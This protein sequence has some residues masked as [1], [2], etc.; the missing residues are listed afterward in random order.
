MT[1]APLDRA[2]WPGEGHAVLLTPDEGL[3]V[4]APDGA[5][6]VM[7]VSAYLDGPGEGSGGE[8]IG[9]LRGCW[10]D[11]AGLL[12]SATRIAPLALEAADAAAA[13]VDARAGR[14]LFLDVVATAF[15]MAEQHLLRLREA[16]EAEGAAG[17]H[18]ARLRYAFDEPTDGNSVKSLNKSQAF[19]WAMIRLLAGAED[20][21]AFRRRPL[22][23]ALRGALASRLRRPPPAAGA[24]L[25]GGGL[26]RLKGPLET[27][28]V[29]RIAEIAPET[30]HVPALRSGGLRDRLA[31]ALRGPVRRLLAH[32]GVPGEVRE[33]FL[34]LL[35]A[36]V[37]TT[38]LE[39]GAVNLA[40]AVRFLDAQAARGVVTATGQAW[41]D[42][43][44]FS[45]AASIRLGLPSAIL[46]HGG[47]YGYDDKQLAFF[48]LDQCLP[49]HFVSWGWTRYSSAFDG[50]PRR[51][52]IVPLPSPALSAR[53]AAGV[54]R[55]AVARPRTLLIPLSKSRTIDQRFGGSAVDANIARLRGMVRR[56]IEVGGFEEYVVSARSD[57]SRP[58]NLAA[59]LRDVPGRRVRL[60]SSMDRPATELMAEA[61]AVFW[62]VATTGMWESLSLGVPTVVALEAGRWSE[63]AGDDERTLL[64][65][66]IAVRDAEGAARALAR[67]AADGDAWAEALAA[68]APVVGR[69]A[70]TSADWRERWRSWGTAAFGLPGPAVED[71]G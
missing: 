42:P 59:G 28:F 66:G 32:H 25:A 11:Q 51:A 52:E 57:P 3:R 62:D 10:R 37:P 1:A 46:Q 27:A 15:G 22:R 53:V 71:R 55:P 23:A 5:H 31:Q 2:G 19:Q 68:A 45:L 38:R 69:Y 9:Y 36:I 4:R 24:L 60:V 21:V 16:R 18:P 67:F 64:D 39:G 34:A 43:V 8:H 41:N 49:T 29:T 33:R 30:V 50:V 26:G 47:Q 40:R 17:C 63:D 13:L 35:T 54:R 65:A 6:G 12:R 44:V 61:D 58:E 56:I 7:P 70:L 20:E 48:L 14:A